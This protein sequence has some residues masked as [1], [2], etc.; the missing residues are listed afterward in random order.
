MMKEVSVEMVQ[1]MVGKYF[2]GVRGLENTFFQ[3]IFRSFSIDF[4][5]YFNSIFKPIEQKNTSYIISTYQIIS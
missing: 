4:S 1:K 3:V 5:A 2:W